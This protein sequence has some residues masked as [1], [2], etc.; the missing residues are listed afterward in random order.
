[1]PKLLK[2]LL[3]AAFFNA[4]SWIILIPIWQYPDEQAHFAQVQDLAQIGYIPEEGFDTSQE[5]A[6]SEKVF[7]TERDGFGNNRYTYHPEFN[8]EYSNS[9]NGL[10]ENYI[11]SFDEL[12]RTNLVKREATHNP[13]LY[14]FLGSLFFTGAFFSVTFLG[15]ASFFSSIVYWDAF[16]FFILI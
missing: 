4:L 1:M 7:G 9:N 6:I 2:L 16:E 12:S 3:I 13:P 5:I 10:F 14:Y 11:E 8:T 15:A